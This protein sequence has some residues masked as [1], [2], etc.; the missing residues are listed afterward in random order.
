MIGFRIHRSALGILAAVVLALG[1]GAVLA[2]SS[3]PSSDPTVPVEFTGRF[4]W[5]GQ[6]GVGTETQVGDRLEIRG[7]VFRPTVVEVS[8]PRLSGAITFTNDLDVHPIPGTE[9][10]VAV[11]WR[12]WRIENEAGAW[13]GSAH[14]VSFAD[15]SRATYV[16]VLRGEGAYEGLIAP[17][18]VTLDGQA[19]NLNGVIVTGPGPGT[20]GPD[21]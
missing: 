8:D 11:W 5:G 6:T 7:N 12:T 4:A 2:Q 13:Q 20:S 16:V 14:D 10:A 3:V 1:P 17:M 18:E 9:T 19:W 15:D 21:S